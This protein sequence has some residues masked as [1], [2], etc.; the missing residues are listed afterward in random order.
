MSGL[1][2]AGASVI[3]TRPAASAGALVRG[4][5][6]RGGHAVRLPGMRLIGIDD[7]A[8]A[9]IQL[10]EAGKADIWIFTSPTAVLFG[11]SLIDT[12]SLPGSL[13][14][15]AVGAGTARALA[16]NGIEAMAPVRMHN[17]EGLLDE[18]AL[19]GVAGQFIVLIDAPGGRELL[20]PTLR[21]RGARVERIAVYERV[22]P[23]L[24]P[25]YLN[26]LRSAERPWITLLSSGLAL[27]NL[28]EALPSELST[29]WR[30]E[31]LVVSSERLA[32]QAHERGFSD[33]HQ[34]AS[35][36]PAD[37]LDCAGRVLARHRL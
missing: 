35:A 28:L 4:T 2:L 29:R 37:L 21:D 15:F 23:R 3:V 13:R 8:G 14:I 20:A 17:S 27:S 1:A 24:T 33:V 22:P 32:T 12:S 7:K 31:A 10:H 11:L 6:S 25:R 30:A 9:R 19:A 5:R 18:P 26:G 34:A 16:R 36:L